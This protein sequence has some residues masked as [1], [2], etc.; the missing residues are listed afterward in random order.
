VPD[1]DATAQQALMD[2]FLEAIIVI[3][4]SGKVERFNAAAENTFGYKRDEVIGRNVSILM[5]SPDREH[6]KKYIQ[7][8]LTSGVKKIIGIGREVQ[9]QRKD[10][11]YFPA[12][13]AIG[14][15]GWR[16]AIRF[17]AMMRDLT[18]KKAAEE[19][20][21]RLHTDMITASRLTTMGEMAAAMAHEINQ[22]LA[23]IAN[24][25][26]AGSRMLD[27]G[28]EHL[29]DV[30]AALKSIDAQAHRA[31]EIIRHLRNFVRPEVLSRGVANLRAIVEDI[32]PLAELDARANSIALVFDLSPDIPDI[33]ADQL[34]IQQVILN[35]IRN[36]IDAMSDARP[37][38]RQLTLVGY[39]PSA[40]KVRVDV[41]DRGQGITEEVSRNLF[42]PF[43]TTKSSGMGMGL[44]ICKTIVSAHGGTLSYANN[45][46]AGA[47]FSVTLPTEV[48]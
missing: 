8:Y 15:V 32:K 16:G 36:G 14:E 1:F 42:N 43:Y 35:L 27:S 19:R 9:A 46:D 37:E 47:T 29:D 3:D 18:D 40:E 38:D 26:S 24:Y 2:A 34:Q 12:H 6:H 11:S 25:A 31:G 21:L 28:S 7:R 41:I 44:A 33:E 30:R 48:V 13:L 22:P 5:P 10:G 23:A 39:Q 20:T 4:S 45:L 17:V